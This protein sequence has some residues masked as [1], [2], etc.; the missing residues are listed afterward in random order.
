[1]D[2]IKKSYKLAIYLLKE[3]IRDYSQAIEGKIDFKLTILAKR[4]KL[5]ERLLLE[6]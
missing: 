4:F 6:I 1:M 5:K 2:E 3:E